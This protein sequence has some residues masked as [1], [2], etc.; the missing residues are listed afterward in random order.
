MTNTEKWKRINELIKEIDDWGFTIGSLEC[1]AEK[2]DAH[3][4][5]CAINTTF[6]F[7]DP[8][9]KEPLLNLIEVTRTLCDA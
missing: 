8:C 7:V 1:V 2:Q 4:L 3:E 6:V 5:L 9:I